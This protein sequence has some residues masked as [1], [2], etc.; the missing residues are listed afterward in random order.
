MY[1]LSPRAYTKLS[2]HFEYSFSYLYSD[3][4][5]MLGFLF[6]LLCSRLTS[7]TWNLLFHCKGAPK[8]KVLIEL[9]IDRADINFYNLI[10]LKS[11]FGFAGRDILYY[12]KRC[13]SD[14][15]NLTPVDYDIETI[16]MIQN[17]I[18]EKK[19]RMLLSR[20]QPTQLHVSITPMKRSRVLE[21]CRDDPIDAYKVWLRDLQ[22]KVKEKDDDDND[23]DDGDEEG[24]K[25]QEPSRLCWFNHNN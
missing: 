7:Q 21:P 18:K 1:F 22:R 2:I 9:K 19:V 20:D 5:I 3:H 15:A 23:D 17:N 25:Q 24:G 12:K 13:G 11:K 4:N 6:F 8:D 10:F 16:E 14:K